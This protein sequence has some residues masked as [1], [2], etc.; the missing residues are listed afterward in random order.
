[1]SDHMSIRGNDG[2]SMMVEARLFGW[3]TGV[4][5]SKTVTKGVPSAMSRV[6]TPWAGSPPVP[7]LLRARNTTSRSTFSEGWL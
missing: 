4:L 1:M 7:P 3:G 2:G 6:K 5:R